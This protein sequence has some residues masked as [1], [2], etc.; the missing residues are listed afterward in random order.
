[1]LLQSRITVR[2][3][4]VMWAPG[5]RGEMAIPWELALTLAL[6]IFF[7]GSCMTGHDILH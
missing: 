6:R 2:L 4:G 7:P 3:K 1:M 5:N